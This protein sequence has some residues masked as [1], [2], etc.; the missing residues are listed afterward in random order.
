MVSLTNTAVSLFGAR[1]VVPGAGILLQNGMIWFDP[2]PGRINSIA[3][4]K[5]PLVNM[6]PVLGFRRGAPLVT[7]GAPGGR[8]IV[9]V[10]PQII[11]NMLDAGDSPQAAMEA[12]RLYTE[13]GDLWVDERAG[14]ANLAALRRMKHPVVAKATSIGTFHFARPVAIRVGRAGLE[15]GLDPLSDASAAGA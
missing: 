13:G 12:P 8:K 2:E 9:A 3:P 14:A 4:G 15:A 5:R 1:M 10:I 6:V 11:S 7:L